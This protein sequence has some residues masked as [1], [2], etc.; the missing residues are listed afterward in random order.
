MGKPAMRLRA[1]SAE[2][3]L[4]G[5]DRSVLDTE[6]GLFGVFDGVG[7]IRDSDRAADLAARII[8]KVCRD[9]SELSLDALVAACDAA[10]EAI[11]QG[12][13]G[14]TTAAVAWIVD[15]QL[16][17]VSIGDSRIY[18]STAGR[19]RQITQDQGEGN[20]VE[21]VLGE[22]PPPG[23]QSLTQQNGTLAVMPGDKLI[24]VTDGITG[25]FWPDLLSLREIAAAVAEDEPHAAAHN[26]IQAARKRDDRTAVVVFLDHG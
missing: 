25:D 14:A 15:E 2:R 12:R 21:N 23:Y 6:L 1:A 19:L 9:S 10:Q 18:L 5:D 3:P 16:H 11:V 13:L 4:H 24:L 8:A 20:L 26:L 7:S 22:S 17:Y